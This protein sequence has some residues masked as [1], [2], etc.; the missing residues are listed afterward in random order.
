MDLEAWAHKCRSFY[1]R[2]W[3]AEDGIR[4]LKS[5]V[6]LERVRV[7]SR[8]ALEQTINIAALAMTV[9]AL[10]AREPAEWLTELPRAGGTRQTRANFLFYRIR[11]SLAHLLPLNHLLL[12]GL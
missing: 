6:S 10:I 1:R 4:F 8:R 5:E 2:R 11:R 3:R 7:M 12:S 9:I